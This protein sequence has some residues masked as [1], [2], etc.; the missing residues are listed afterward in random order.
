MRVD[1]EIAGLLLEL[2]A[3]PKG[4]VELEE[5]AA[6]MHSWNPAPAPQRSNW[7]R[8][9]LERLAEPLYVMICPPALV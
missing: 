1:P 9:V 4:F 5:A 6:G 2:A 7:L 8:M 3:G